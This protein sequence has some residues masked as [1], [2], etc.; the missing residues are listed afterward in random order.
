[1]LTAVEEASLIGCNAPEGASNLHAH[2][3]T[4]VE[5][6]CNSNVGEEKKDSFADREP[7]PEKLE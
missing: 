3:Q 6:Q 7:L 4:S 5:P 2:L 1:M